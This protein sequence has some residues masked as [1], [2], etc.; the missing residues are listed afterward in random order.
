[1]IVYRTAQ[2]YPELVTHLFSVC[3]PFAPPSSEFISTADLVAG[4][5]PQ[6]GYQLQLAGPDVEAGIQSE[7]QIRNFLKGMFGG[8]GEGGRIM[9]K[10]ETGVQFDVL[11]TVGMTS[12]LNEEVSDDLL[13]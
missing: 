7:D 1:M 6:F 8:R 12:L 5:L 9:F 10:P 4:P 13:C 3:T 2:W 11:P